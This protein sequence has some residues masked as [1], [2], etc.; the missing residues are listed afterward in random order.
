M[1]TEEEKASIRLKNRLSKKKKREQDKIALEKEIEELRRLGKE[2]RLEE[3]RRC[4]ILLD[5][6]SRPKTQN[7][8]EETQFRKLYKQRIRANAPNEKIEFDRIDVCSAIQSNGLGS[9]EV[10]LFEQGVFLSSE[11]LYDIEAYVKNSGNPVFI[12]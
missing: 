2:E 12:L 1:K 3:L 7:D 11:V 4:G 6:P 5:K 8:E 10:D 9:A